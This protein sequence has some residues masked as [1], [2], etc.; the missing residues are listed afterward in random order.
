[1]SPSPD[2]PAGEWPILLPLPRA[3]RHGI[4]SYLGG[5]VIGPAGWPHHDL[6]FLT[7]GSAVFEIGK[8]TLTAHAG[9]A[10]FIPPHHS[11][12]GRASADGCAI[13]V[14]HYVSV[15]PSGNADEG[16]TLWR[17][18]GADAWV[19]TLMQRVRALQTGRVKVQRPRT[20]EDT[21]LPCLIVL[22]VEAMRHAAS[23]AVAE[24]SPAAGRVLRAI[25]WAR[26]HASSLASIESLAARAELSPSQFRALFRRLTGTPAGRFLRDLRLDE[27]ARLLQETRLPIK[28][29][30]A[31]FGYSDPVAFHRAFALKTGVTPA[32]FRAGS[33]RVV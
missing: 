33:A 11:F 14:Q 27:A 5:A 3:V 29:I 21:E 4:G 9:D 32:R 20:A 26:S 1:V 30:S 25:D 16:P 22:L 19:R 31:R 10:L 18:A 23:P 12:V 7:R 24:N 8:V 15:A 28:E 13:W 2:S 17:G 6:I